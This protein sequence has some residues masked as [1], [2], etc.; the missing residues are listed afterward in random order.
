MPITSAAIKSVRQNEKRRQLRRPV[1]TYM[2][3]QVKNLQV[4]VN[5]GKTAEA[6]KVL[7]QVYKAIDMA[8]KRHLIHRNQAARKKSSMAKL[9]AKS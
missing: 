2:K 6:V 9:V 5:E 4:L 8:A 3:T 7:P 1:L